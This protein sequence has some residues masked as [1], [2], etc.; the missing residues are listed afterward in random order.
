MPERA[1]TPM[2]RDYPT[3]CAW[4]RHQTVSTDHLRNELERALAWVEGGA[5]VAPARDA[6]DWED[7][8]DN[9]LGYPGHGG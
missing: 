3:I 9:P 6:L 7:D 5:A 4:T 1:K 2:E 8:P